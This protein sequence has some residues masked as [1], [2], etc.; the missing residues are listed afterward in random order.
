MLF[1]ARGLE[2]DFNTIRIMGI[3][4]ITPDS[5]SDGGMFFDKAKA[6]AHALDMIK[7]KAD[8][9]DIGGESTRPGAVKISAE[10]ES[11]RIVSVISEIR[12]ADSNI[13]I[14]VDTYKAVVAENA[15]RAGADIINDISGGTY[16]PKIMKIAAAAKAGFI[17]MHIKGTPE[18]MQEN[19]VY[20]ANGVVSDINDFFK[21]Q[22]A[23]ALAAGL[24]KDNIILD[25][26]I[27][28]GKTLK[29]NFEIIDQFSEFK[30]FRLP[31]LIGTSRKSMI[32]KVLGLD[33]DKRLFGTA[34]S[35]ALCTAK[36]ADILRV[37]DVKEMRETALMTR[38]MTDY[39]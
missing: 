14:S 12:A 39:K 24:S 23:I 16:E 31:V 1:K 4:N 32:G 34:A 22:I 30:R 37:H 17:I 7:D 25:P 10:E 5:F 6:L 18:T 26:G 19:P 33:A 21:Q 13:L 38:A 11:Q 9:I 3:L 20:S 28:F 15:L 2:I 8:I 29:N 35:V 36:G 27:G